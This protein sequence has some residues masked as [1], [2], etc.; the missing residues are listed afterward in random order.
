MI[1]FYIQVLQ[2]KASEK[3]L[4]KKAETEGPVSTEERNN[5]FQSTYK[6]HYAANH[7]SLVSAVT[8]PNLLVLLKGLI[9]ILNSKAVL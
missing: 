6:Q 4:Q 3:V 9:P 5:I 8:W 1:A 7:H 2:K